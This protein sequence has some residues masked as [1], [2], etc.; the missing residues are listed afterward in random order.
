M[1]AEP[2]GGIDWEAKKL[3]TLGAL[4][5]PIAV[6]MLSSS[7]MSVADT[8]FVGR[9]GASALAGV[10]MASTLTW[11]LICFAFGLLRAVK[12]LVSQA[13]GAG[14]LE[15]TREYLFAGKLLGFSIGVVLII[16]VPLV[17]PGL[18]LLLESE[19]AS[20]A[21]ADYFRVRMISIPCLLMFVATREYRY[22]MGDMRLPMVA[23]VVANILN[24]GLDYAFIVELEW[25]VEGAA[26]A[27]VA[28]V[29]VEWMIV[30][31]PTG[32]SIWQGRTARWAH[33]RSI[34]SIGTPSGLQFTLE[35]GSFTLLAAMIARLGD[36]EMAAH[37]IA[38]QV[39]HVAFLPVVS[40]GEGASV[41][42][43]QA[44]GAKRDDLIVPVS[45]LAMRIGFI[46][47]AGCAAILLGLGQTIAEIFAT[48][49]DLVIGVQKLLMVAAVFLLGDSVNIVCRCVLRGLGDV[50]VP[51]V[52]GIVLAWG[53]T[54]PLMWWLGYLMG[55]G[56]MG[57]WMGLALE[58]F[59][60]AGILGHR[61]RAGHWRR[62]ALESRARLEAVEEQRARDKLAVSDSTPALSS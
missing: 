6:S 46:Y 10:G 18:R 29:T 60:S 42:A 58:V 45:R 15:Q 30:L 56:A 27:T 50:R 31:V 25:G 47:M 37:Q 33:L 9:L 62:A 52:V 5:W 3:R 38:L 24:V 2:S 12:V 1:S 39:I 44:V 48:E 54:P 36:V 61:L 19:A 16:A 7:L 13:R 17:E 35:M 43:G 51:A 40:L 28:A 41:M 14:Q 34:V 11:A 23:G 21:A 26:W 53:C 8:Y 32:T 57:G 4:A 22:G 55:M 20:D 59:L 49:S